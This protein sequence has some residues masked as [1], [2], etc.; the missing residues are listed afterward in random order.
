MVPDLFFSQLVLVA[1]V[2]VCLMLHG[3]WPRDWAP[4]PPTPPPPTPPRRQHSREPHPFAGLT[5]PPPGD[6]CEPALAAPPPRLVP[7]RGRPRQVDTSSHCCPHP[8][9]ASRGWLGLGH[10]SANGHPCV[11]RAKVATDAG[12]TLPPLPGEGGH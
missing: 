12:R 9:G 8:H 1:L 6:A 10:L 2:W 3:V 4:A 11:F 7:P 5:R